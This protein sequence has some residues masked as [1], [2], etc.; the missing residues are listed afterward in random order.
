MVYTW[1]GV[2][3]VTILKA[4]N[5]SRIL[6]H[7]VAYLDFQA[8][9]RLIG[10]FLLGVLVTRAVLFQLYNGDSEF[11]KL[12]YTAPRW[13]LVFPRLG[14]GFRELQLAGP[15]KMRSCSPSGSGCSLLRHLTEQNPSTTQT[16]DRI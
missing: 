9:G 11:W 15:W 1:V 7:Q 5:L 13:G 6:Q 2:G 3:H 16:P 8:M 12:S 10:L 4:H 14:S